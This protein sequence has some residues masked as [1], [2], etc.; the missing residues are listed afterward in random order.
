MSFDQRWSKQDISCLFFLYFLL[1]RQLENVLES[2]RKRKKERDRD[3]ESSRKRKRRELEWVCVWWRK[4]KRKKKEKKKK[5][6]M[7]EIERK[8]NI[9]NKK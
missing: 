5:K 3:L 1:H 7:D 4:N 9:K 2:S 8:N 6:R